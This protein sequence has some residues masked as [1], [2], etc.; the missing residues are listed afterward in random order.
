MPSFNDSEQGCPPKDTVALVLSVPASEIVY[1]SAVLEGYEGVCVGTTSAEEPTRI[2]LQV[3]PG[4]VH[5]VREVL[6][7]LEL[8]EGAPWIEALRP[9]SDAT[10]FRR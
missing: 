1:V 7:S 10:S 4:Q 3:S 6:S 2:E 9:G 5:L 8:T